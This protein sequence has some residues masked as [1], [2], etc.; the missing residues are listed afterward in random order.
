MIMGTDRNPSDSEH[1]ESLIVNR[2]WRNNEDSTM[3]SNPDSLC[4]AYRELAKR[5]EEGSKQLLPRL[6]QNG[7]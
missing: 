6:Y 1:S 7:S 5:M 3:P 4:P 2:A